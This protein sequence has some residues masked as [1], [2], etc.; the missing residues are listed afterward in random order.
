MQKRRGRPGSIYCVS[1][2]NVYLH[3]IK[4]RRPQWRLVNQD[5][6]IN[7]KSTLLD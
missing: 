2:I 6:L 1:N 5:E 3:I 4:Q 7:N